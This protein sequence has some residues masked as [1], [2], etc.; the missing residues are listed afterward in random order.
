MEIINIDKRY[1]YLWFIYLYN[2]LFP[3]FCK[4]YNIFKLR[5]FFSCIVQNAKAK[6]CTVDSFP[7]QA[8]FITE[9]VAYIYPAYFLLKKKNA[10]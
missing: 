1:I 4:E 6:T 8:N 5:F 9:R 7:E 3:L 2:F 10:L